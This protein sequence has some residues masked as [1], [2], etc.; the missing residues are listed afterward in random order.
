MKKHP[1]LIVIVLLSALLSFSLLTR[2][3]VWWDDFASY[4]MQAQSL[5]RG[6]TAD[7]VK[8]NSF[9][10]Q[11]SSYP[12]G[13]IAYPWGFPLLLAPALA[14]F[15][16]KVLALKLVNTLTFALFLICFQRLARLR[17]TEGW[18]LLLTALLAFNP[19][20]LLGHDYILSDIPFLLFSTLSLLI[21]DQW[22]GSESYLKQLL[23]ALAIF[24]AYF[25][26]T[27]GIL[28]LAPLAI[29]QFDLQKKN[30]ARSVYSR[31][32]NN[33]PRLLPPYLI[34][35]VLFLLDTFLLPRGQE[36]YFSHFS[37]F[38]FERFLGNVIYYL[39]LPAA[40]FEYIPLGIVFFFVTL[41]FFLVG[42]IAVRRE[43]LHFLV[44]IFL[45]ILLFMLWPE[46]QGLRFIY[47]ILPLFILIAAQGALW[48][49]DR[50]SQPLLGKAAFGFWLTLTAISFGV[51]AWNGW[52]NLKDDRY[53]NGPFD[54]VSSEMF[55]FIRE[56]TPPDSVI[57]FFKPRVM[58]LLTDRDSFL[59][60][61]CGDLTKGDYIVIHEKQGGNGQLTQQ[62]LEACGA[63]LESVFNNKRFTVY[64]ISP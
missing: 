18:S 52:I 35:G 64:K 46:T 55:E 48:L 24:T 6:S 7:F 63:P 39:K 49:A 57:I 11:E 34:F 10:I 61:R 9:T 38:T 58:R 31:V 37:M 53:I 56:K 16:L 23:I 1:A 60:D 21:I 47:P 45:A 14:I 54:P 51:S 44:Y 13:P 12:V 22:A 32:E 59:T 36:S 29:A 50:L 2:G 33:W 5:L 26:R 42:A 20:L 4:I 40:L 3:H 30:S 8:H 27:N 28:L 25:I 62:A 43:N 15:G 19:A 41:L 17:L